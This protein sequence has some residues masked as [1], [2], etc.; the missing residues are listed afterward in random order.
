M[1]FSKIGTSVFSAPKK[2]N[3]QTQAIASLVCYRTQT[4]FINEYPELLGNVQISSFSDGILSIIVIDATTASLIF[5]RKEIL[6]KLLADMDLPV[7]IN[8]IQIKRK[9]IIDQL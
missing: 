7:K 8:D 5:M 6:L 3:L 2:Y 4:I 1:A 9:D